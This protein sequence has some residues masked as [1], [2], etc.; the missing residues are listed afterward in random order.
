MICDFP[1]V[2]ILS[3]TP[4][5]LPPRTIAAAL[6][7][8]TTFLAVPAS[9]QT[10]TLDQVSPFASE[11]PGNPLQLNF[12]SSFVTWQIEVFAGMDGTLE[13]FELELIGL[14]GMS[15]EAAIILGGPW[16]TGT[17]VWSGSV[18]KT[19]DLTEIVF[20][21]TSAAGIHLSMHDA[22]TIKISSLTFNGSSLWGTGTSQSPVNL[23]YPPDLF[24]NGSLFNAD[25]RIGFHTYM[26]S[27]TL[28]LTNL[29]GGSPATVAVANCTTGGNVLIGYSATGAG[30]T[31]TPFGFADL[32]TPIYQL[33]TLTADALGNVSMTTNVPAG[34]VGLTLWFQALDFSAGLFS[35]GVQ[36]T[37]Q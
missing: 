16:T 15:C 36:D 24:L 13:G 8:I 32:S 14:T 30:P 4:G 3:Y 19:N 10:G 35:N 18:T 6:L 22:Y 27:P 7:G 34:R 21:D 31:P 25:S 37:I 9:A 11:Q 2:L 33:P 12:D 20:V 26:R 5:M 23:F 29:V 28:T 1:E 17:P